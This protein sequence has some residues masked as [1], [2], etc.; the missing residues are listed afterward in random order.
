MKAIIRFTGFELQKSHI[1]NREGIP[2]PVW[3]LCGF[4][5]A[6]ANE[7]IHTFE[8]LRSAEIAMSQ[9]YETL[10]GTTYEVES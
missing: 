4:T 3:A 7:I 6:G 8:D 10:R 9:W 2:V 1:A 5:M